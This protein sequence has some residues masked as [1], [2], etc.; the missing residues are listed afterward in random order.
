MTEITSLCLKILGPMLEKLFIW[1]FWGYFFEEVKWKKDMCNDYRNIQRIL[2]QP[3]VS[4]K[5]PGRL[6]IETRPTTNSDVPWPAEYHQYFINVDGGTQFCMNWYIIEEEAWVQKTIQDSKILLKKVDKLA[7]TPP[8]DNFFAMFSAKG[9]SY[10]KL[11]WELTLKKSCASSMWQKK[12]PIKRDI[13]SRKTASIHQKIII[14]RETH[15][16]ICS[17][18]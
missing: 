12:L 8:S 11:N 7:N 15:D 14:P 17:F 13:R 2:K 5:N 3:I 18:D 9:S 1:Y 16:Q 4:R 6:D 10:I